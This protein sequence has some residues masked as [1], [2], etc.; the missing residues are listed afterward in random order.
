MGV[1]A[2]SGDMGVDADAERVCL[3]V[4]HHRKDSCALPLTRERL[5]HPTGQY[6]TRR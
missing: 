5:R 4:A 3:V 6:P 1:G 2:D